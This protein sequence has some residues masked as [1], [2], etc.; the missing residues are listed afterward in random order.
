MSCHVSWKSATLTS[1]GWFTAGAK[2]SNLSED[3]IS[4]HLQVFTSTTKM[5]NSSQIIHQPN[6]KW[7]PK[8]CS[9]KINL[10]PRHLDVRLHSFFQAAEFGFL[11]QVSLVQAWKTLKTVGCYLKVSGRIRKWMEMSCQ[12][13][14][15]TWPLLRAPTNS[16]IFDLHRL[17]ELIASEISEAT[18][19]PMARP[20]PLG[21]H[22]GGVHR[23]ILRLQRSPVPV[24]RAAVGFWGFTGWSTYR[25]RSFTPGISSFC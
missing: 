14:P 12:K 21:R 10:L 2:V 15:S 3:T 6:R 24:F 19:W 17:G 4:H 7:L 25:Q 5:C 8:K 9:E 13:M 22:C 18:L 1:L 16:P 20:G 23:D 11:V